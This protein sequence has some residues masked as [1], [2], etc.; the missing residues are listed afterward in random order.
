MNDNFGNG[1][2][3]DSFNVF[4]QNAEAYK[5]QQEL[6]KQQAEAA[7]QAAAAQQQALA[8]Q[9]AQNLQ[10]QEIQNIQE[11]DK[12]PSIF[13][14]L[15][16]KKEKKEERKFDLND[17]STFTKAEKEPKKEMDEKEKSKMELILLIV[18]LVVLGVVGYW[19]FTVFMNTM[20]IDNNKMDNS[21][22]LIHE[23]VKKVGS[24]SCEKDYDKFYMVLPYNDIIQRQLSTY[25]INYYSDENNNVVV[26]E[27]N[28]LINYGNIDMATKNELQKWCNSYNNIND[29][30]QLTCNLKNNVMLIKN[31]FDLTKIDGKVTNGDIVYDIGVTKHDLIKDVINTESENGSKCEMI[32]TEE[33][34]IVA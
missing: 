34:G 3:D 10:Q 5:Q 8:N 14:M 28:V 17:P 29:S 16:K 2:N 11:V 22:S 24:Y 25:T 9:H 18:L 21:N 4:N 27:E 13:S 19:A 30:Y 33:N 20:G 6:L 26:K 23:E 32:N 7:A 1:M 31:S 15:G 12:N